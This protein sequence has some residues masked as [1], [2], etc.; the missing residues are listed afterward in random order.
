MTGQQG[1]TGYTGQQGDTGYTGQQGDTGAT[2]DTGMTGQQGDTGAT[3]QQGDTGMTGQQGDTGYTGQQGDTGYTGQQGDT[4][5]TGMQMLYMVNSS[6]IEVTTDTAITGS[7]VYG[8]DSTNGAISILLPS[9]SDFGIGNY[10]IISDVGG[11]SSSN[12]IT[13]NA[14]GGDTING[15]MSISIIKDYHSL[16][17]ISYSSNKWIIV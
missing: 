7:N 15:V 11:N 9:I 12:P 2:G 17:F 14:S 16:Y 13:I 8:V 5:Y 10:I 6:P 4:G 3:G 1:D